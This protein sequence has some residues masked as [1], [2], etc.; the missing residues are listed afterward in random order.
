MLHNTLSAVLT[1]K[2]KKKKNFYSSYPKNTQKIM[3]VIEMVLKELQR[4]NRILFY[5]TSEKQVKG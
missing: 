2:K 3:N 4:H 1:I 5:S